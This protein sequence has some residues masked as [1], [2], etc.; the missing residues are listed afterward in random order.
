MS[1]A[2]QHNTRDE[3]T[4]LLA[5]KV[6]F[7]ASLN[8]NIERNKHFQQP[9][10][11]PEVDLWKRKPPDFSIQLF[12]SLRL[13]K[14]SKD[15]VV[16]REALSRSSLKLLEPVK[17]LHKIS[18][19][20]FP[21]LTRKPQPERFLTRFQ[22]VGP[23]EAKLMFVKNG[24]YS[25]DAY[26]DPKPHDFR[27]FEN[28]IPDFVTSCSRDPFDLKLKCQQLSTVHELP[29]LAN[30]QKSTGAGTRNFIT[31]KPHEVKWDS[32]LILPKSSYPPKSASY[33]RYRRRRDVYSAFM[34]RVEEKL[35]KTWQEGQ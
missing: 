25:S 14:N 21:S 29:S 16:K 26:K 27:Q 1:S 6:K 2:S 17:E 20:C 19:A 9:H 32:R 18:E 12:R 11:V 30:K 15:S 13:S 7:S 28:D 22:H 5:R 4:C 23:Y 3:M 34:D 24:K 33:T 31:Y 10:S 8:L 35:T